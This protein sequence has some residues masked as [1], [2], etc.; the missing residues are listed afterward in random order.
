MKKSFLTVLTIAVFLWPMW[1][2]ADWKITTEKI[3]PGFGHPESVAYDPSAGVLYVSRFGEEL[4]PMQKDGQGV[5]SLV[6]LEG[7]ILEEKFLPGPDDEL[8]KPKGISTA[9]GRLWVTDIDAVWVFDIK[10][11]KGVRAALPNAAFANDSEVCGGLL[12]VSDTGTGTLYRIKPADFLNEK[13]VV[14]KWIQ[15]S[16]LAPNGLWRTSDGRILFC[17]YPGQSPPGRIYRLLGRDK[18]EP[19]S[20]ELGRLDGLAMLPD[21]TLIYTDWEGKGLFALDPDGK[22]RLLVG[23]ISGPA[24]F[25][26]VP[27]NGIYLLVV[28]DLVK[29][30]LRFFTLEK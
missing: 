5:I 1:A 12:Y 19:I 8:N 7:N 20:E 6:D 26:L 15:Q 25:A 17:T 30:D 3:V 9:Q 14:D 13:P 29:G 4:K 10:T 11:K 23:G 2:T 18:F 16:G 27:N 21:G 24:D 22:S 28:P